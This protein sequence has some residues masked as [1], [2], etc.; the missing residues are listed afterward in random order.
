MALMM[1]MVMGIMLGAVGQSW[2]TIMQREREEELLFRGRQYR[3]AIKRWYNPRPG[4]GQHV[5][6]PL[7]EL[8]DLTEDPRSLTKARYLRRLY[9]DPMTGKE[10][11]IFSDPNKGI[12]GVA[13]TS[14]GK[15][16]K[17]GGFPEDLKY[18]AGKEHYSDWIFGR[19]SGASVTSGMITS[20]STLTSGSSR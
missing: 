8:K 10:W 9:T 7:K 16:L 19:Y 4:S 12:S 1:V 18:L 5:A 13:S 20:G 2:K 3:D 11:A 15:P 6:T 17:T 14:Q